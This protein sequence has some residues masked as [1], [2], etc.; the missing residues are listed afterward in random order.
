MTN[1]EYIFE[2]ANKHNFKDTK[3]QINFESSIKGKHGEIYANDLD[4]ISIK[5]DEDLIKKEIN[6]E[7]IRFDIDSDFPEDVFFI[8]QK[9]M[10]DV[11]FRNWIAMGRYIPTI[12]KNVDFFD[13]IENLTKEIELKIESVFSSIEIDDGDSDF[14]YDDDGDSDYYDGED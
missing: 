7:D 8:W 12:V 6:I 3:C 13:E 4:I 14:E 10:P 11:S 1:I 2:F 5:F 9:D